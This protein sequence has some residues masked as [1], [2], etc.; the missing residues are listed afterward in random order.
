MKTECSD[1]I[2]GKKAAAK[3]ALNFVQTNM[4]LGLGTGSTATFFL[5]LLARKIRDE[6]LN[7]VGV[8]TSLATFEKS[9]ELK[10]PLLTMEKV[11]KIDLV[12]DGA[13]EF[14]QNFN[15]I[16]GGGG[17]LLQEKIVA[18]SSSQMIVITDY[19]KEVDCLGR[20]PLPVEIV[21]FGATFTAKQIGIL[22]SD[23]GFNG[24]QLNFRKKDKDYFITDEGHY[25]L[26]LKLGEISNLSRLESQLLKCPGV[27]ETGLF[28]GLAK[29]IIVGQPDGNC[30]LIGLDEDS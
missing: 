7:I 27:V 26:D 25:I 16:K 10:I 8:A 30:K 9:Q 11:Q 18:R 21:K 1:Q 13:D 6:G 2:S 29:T 28:L 3:R 20:F 17:A 24:T 22:L 12:V 5:E 19:S 14:D 15:L 23:L 4:I